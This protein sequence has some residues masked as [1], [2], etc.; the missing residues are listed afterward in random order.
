M[1]G[2]AITLVIVS[3]VLHAAWNGMA[4]GGSV[5]FTW[6]YFA[7]EVLFVVPLA[8][9]TTLLNPPDL[10]LGLALFFMAGTAVIHAGYFLLLMQGYRFGDLSVVYP[11]SRATGP[12]V[13]VVFA[14]LL[15]G[16]R[17]TPLAL[18]GTLLICGGVLW[19]T[20]DPRQ[21]MASGELPALAF[22]L[23]TGLSIAAFTL[24]D[25]YAVS[26]VD[27]PPA[28]YQSGNAVGRAL[29]LLPVAWH[30]RDEVGVAWGTHRRS[31]L[32]VGFLIT[33]SY[34]IM[35]AAYAISPV[36]YAA[37]LRTISV[38]FGVLIGTRLLREGH[39]RQRLAAAGAMVAGVLALGLG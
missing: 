5:G 26:Q 1:T 13:V 29:L 6:L 7:C 33:A 11:I 27:I 17:P 36:S 31:A 4:K 23:L 12:L 32:V 9:I 2:L 15:F 38:L 20:G 28:L 39:T 24:W 16:E 21:M 25:S 19:L 3:A 34:T 18:F 30:F 10:D 14:V 37:P 35:L 22:S 8:L